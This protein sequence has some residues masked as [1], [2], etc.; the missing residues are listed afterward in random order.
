MKNTTKKG[1]K[2]IPSDTSRVM[3]IKNDEVNLKNDSDSNSYFKRE[4]S[5]R[6]GDIVFLYN[7][8]LS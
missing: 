3:E 7:F 5:F 2:I 4:M 8:V 6:K 1:E